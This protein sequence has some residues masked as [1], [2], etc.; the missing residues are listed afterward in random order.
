MSEK[1]E[2]KAKRKYN[3]GVSADAVITPIMMVLGI[4]HICL[5]FLIFTI[6]RESGALS[7]VMSD[8]GVYNAEAGNLIGGSSL[9]SETC[10]GFVLRPTNE[11]GELNLGVIM[12]YAKEMAREDRRGPV[13]AA[14]FQDYDVDLEVKN[15]VNETSDATV[16]MIQTQLH[17][18]ALIDSVYKLPDA[19][20]LKE[21]ELPELTEEEKAL[22][23][24]ERVKL[25]Q[26]LIVDI[27]YGNQKSLVSTNVSKIQEMIGK[28]SG[29][30]AAYYSRKIAVLR[31][32][33]WAITIFV[34]LI[35]LI[36]F[37]QIFRHLVHPLERFGTLIAS[38]SY[39]DEDIGLKELKN[40]AISYNGLLER[41]NGLEAILRSAAET[42]TLTGLPNR[43]AFDQY[44]FTS[45]MKGYSVGVILFDVN[46]LKKVN[47]NEGHAAGDRLLRRAAECISECF[48]IPG[49]NNCCRFG[50]DEFAAIIKNS[51]RGDIEER[52][53][54]FISAQ[55]EKNMS[56]SWGFAYADDIGRTTVRALIDEADK[57]MY[58][59]KKEM[60]EKNGD[61]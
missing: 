4:C 51:S 24:D 43:Y 36:T 19:K 54:E 27:D 33:L 11:I 48:S 60:H 18:I 3:T 14:H 28:K 46:Y 50:G 61:E 20:E 31:L 13:I 25:A 2:K 39:L 30:M 59:K 15:I 57:K 5:I 56:I 26:K 47:D 16:S 7:K 45:D 34:I 32:L 52:I 22:S 58:A 41:R 44:I 23:D 29:Q 37:I 21:L 9:L 17:A 42:D 6:N 40:L 1:K 35:L 38:D 49:Q 12:A 8:N 53:E 55:R 10:T